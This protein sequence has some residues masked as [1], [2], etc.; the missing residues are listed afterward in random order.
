MKNRPN[1]S[2][3]VHDGG[4]KELGRQLLRAHLEHRYEDARI[5]L[6]RIAYRATLQPIDRWQPPSAALAPDDDDGM[7]G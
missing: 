5:L 4:R 6:D 3:S 2:L 7:T 1:P